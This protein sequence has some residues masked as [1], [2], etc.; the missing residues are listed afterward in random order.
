LGWDKHHKRSESGLLLLLPAMIIELSP[1]EGGFAM[2][3][4]LGPLLSLSTNLSAANVDENMYLS[5]LN[6]SGA[7][8]SLSKQNVDEVNGKN[9]T[10]RSTKGVH[11]SRSCR[12]RGFK[13]RKLQTPLIPRNGQCTKILC[14]LLKDSKVRSN[15]EKILNET[16]ST[17]YATFLSM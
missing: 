9:R 16:R 4:L 14:I 17:K 10:G 5:A 8:R 13:P 15:D 12:N 3:A 1:R 11:F 2:L 6:S 7:F